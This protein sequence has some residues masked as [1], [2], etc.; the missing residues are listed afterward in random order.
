MLL[1]EH[2]V[3]M[4]AA[5]HFSSMGPTNLS[6]ARSWLSRSPTSPRT[7]ASPSATF[8]TNKINLYPKSFRR[9]A[10]PSETCYDTMMMLTEG[11]LP[12]WVSLICQHQWN[13]LLSIEAEPLNLLLHHSA[14]R[15]AVISA[16]IAVSS[17]L[18]F[19]TSI[20]ISPSQGSSVLP[21]IVSAAL[22]SALSSRASAC[23]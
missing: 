6:F 13:S 7:P 23:Q 3:T 11:D 17:A 21:S 4:V 22:S 16:A 12:L 14:H 15:L 8:P 18:S 1:V 9:A 2:V 5:Q 19:Q 20:V 10:A